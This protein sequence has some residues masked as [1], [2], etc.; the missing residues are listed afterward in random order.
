M[1]LTAVDVGVFEE[2]RFAHQVGLGPG[3]QGHLDED[4]GV[5]PSPRVVSSIPVRQ[6]RA[7]LARCLLRALP[8]GDLPLSRVTWSAAELGPHLVSLPR[9]YRRM[10]ETPQPFRHCFPRRSTVRWPRCSSVIRRLNVPREVSCRA[11]GVVLQVA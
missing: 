4:R 1:E 9:R 11:L 10:A 6:A 8:D 3:G 2:V 7:S 5:R